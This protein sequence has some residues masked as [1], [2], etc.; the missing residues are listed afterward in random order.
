MASVV[1]RRK[2]WNQRHRMTSETIEGGSKFLRVHVQIHLHLLSSSSSFLAIWW[3][4]LYSGLCINVLCPAT[5][6]NHNVVFPNFLQCCNFN[7]VLFPLFI[8][9]KGM[10]V[11][12]PL[13][14]TIFTKYISKLTG[15][16]WNFWIWPKNIERGRLFVLDMTEKTTRTRNIKICLRRTHL[17]DKWL[18]NFLVLFKI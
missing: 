3:D 2:Q 16:C 6:A 10:G 1:T 4:M 8:N 17:N 15:K 11:V 13:K 18:D 9:V 5:K 12:T 14:L 7:A